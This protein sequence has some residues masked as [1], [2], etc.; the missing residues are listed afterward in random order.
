MEC[1]S[2]L[3]RIEVANASLPPEI[4]EESISRGD[5]DTLKSPDAHDLQDSKPLRRV[6]MCLKEM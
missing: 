6:R 4:V 2:L 3:L 1:A 5:E